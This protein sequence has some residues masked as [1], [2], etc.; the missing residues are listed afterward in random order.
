M[1]CCQKV[2]IRPK[3]KDQVTTSTFSLIK[4][5]NHYFKPQKEKTVIAL[6]WNTKNIL[7]KRL[8][9]RPCFCHHRQLWEGLIF[10]FVFSVPSLK[11]D[12]VLHFIHSTSSIQHSHSGFSS[13][14]WSILIFIKVHFAGNTNLLLDNLLVKLKFLVDFLCDANFMYCCRF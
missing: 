10:L 11:F 2:A 1:R 7:L 4:S 3:S 14:I 9:F 5:K 6:S 8:L 13:V 12:S